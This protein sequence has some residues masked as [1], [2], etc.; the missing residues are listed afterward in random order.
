MGQISLTDGAGNDTL[1]GGLDGDT[2]DGGTSDDLLG[3]GRGDLAFG[4]AG[5]DT[6]Q[7]IWTETGN[8]LIAIAGGDEGQ[9][10]LIPSKGRAEMC[11]ICAALARLRLRA[12]P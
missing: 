2:F 5:D 11:W 10:V 9:T 7:L 6:F 3:L 4:D 12:L 1:R 8:A